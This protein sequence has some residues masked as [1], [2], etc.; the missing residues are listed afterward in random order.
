M[1][2]NVRTVRRYRARLSVTVDPSTL[3]AVDAFV[4][5]HPG[6]DRSKIVDE[7]LALWCERE[8][9]RAMVE[10]FARPVSPRE[11]EELRAWQR[12]RRAA[13]TRRLA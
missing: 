2:T 11:A 10:Q 13:A 4:R 8:Q 1:G 12:V 9:E 3:S 7:A 6:L 5:E